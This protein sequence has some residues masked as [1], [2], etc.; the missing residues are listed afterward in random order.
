MRARDFF[1][2]RAVVL[3]AN[4]PRP[5]G[6]QGPCNLDLAGYLATWRSGSA[7]SKDDDWL[8]P[9]RRNRDQTPRSCS[10]LVKDHIGAAAVRAGVTTEGDKRPFG[11][12]ALRHSLAT[13]LISWGTDVKT[14]QRMLRHSIVAT[15][16]EVYTQVV[17]ANCITAQGAMLSPV[18]HPAPP[19][20]EIVL[21]L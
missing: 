18:V 7:Y 12:H 6:A 13:S 19:A 9:S 14:V 2:S 15:T 10:S 21:V 20:K 17:N 5:E 11:L 3:V 8:F 16:L 1:E 4:P